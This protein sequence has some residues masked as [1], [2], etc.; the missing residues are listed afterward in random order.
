MQQITSDHF[1][2]G[3]M[4]KQEAGKWY[5]L[6]VTSNRFPE[7]VKI[8]GGT[9]QNARWET[10]EQTLL[11]E[12]PEE[13]SYTVVDYVHDAVHM[14][15]CDNGHTKNFYLIT[16]ASGKLAIGE[17]KTVNEPD[18]DVLTVRWIELS[19]FIAKLYMVQ[20][21]AFQMAMSKFAELSQ[22]FAED[23]YERI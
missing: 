6:S 5:V 3:V 21:E 15:S 17:S 9:N 14:I 12:F 22:K 16:K 7:S 11:R 23:N 2:G 8:P 10:K 20:R 4:F 19:E 18:G 1:C 13:T